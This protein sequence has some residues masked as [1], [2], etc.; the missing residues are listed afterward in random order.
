[1]SRRQVAV[2]AAFL[3]V[4]LGLGASTVG[5][6]TSAHTSEEAIGVSTS[7]LGT[8]NVLTRAYDNRRSGANTAESILTPSN[9]GSGNLG[10]L[11]QVQV[12]DEVY[13]QILYA[14][15][16]PLPG[17]SRNVIYVATANNS[18]YAIDA[19]TGVVIWQKNY[20]TAFVSTAT[21]PTWQQV[22]PQT[23]PPGCPAY[24]SHVGLIATPVIDAST[25]KMYFVTHTIENGSMVYR[26]HGIDIL[27]GAEASG[28][29]TIMTASGFDSTIQNQRAGLALD[30]GAVYVAFASYC[31]SNGDN[32]PTGYHGWVFAYD[33]SRFYQISA[34]NATPASGALGGIWQ[35]G[36]APAID[37]NG[38][39]YV[40]TGNG[41][42][43]GMANFGE[44]V[45]QLSSRTLRLQT[46]YTPSNFSGLNGQDLDLGAI[47][48]TL[49]S[50]GLAIQGGK[51][52][53]IYNL[54][55]QSLAANPNQ[56]PNPVQGSPVGEYDMH[57]FAVWNNGSADKIYMW[58]AN[59]LPRGFQANGGVIGTTPFAV[60]TIPTT[61]S[62]G[63]MSLSANGTSAG[64]LWAT[65]GLGDKA[66]NENFSVPGVLY[67]LDAATLVQ[68]WSSA[69][70]L[71]Q[72]NIGT[73]A[74][75]VPPTVANGKVYVASG[76]TDVV[77]TFGL[78][79]D[80]PV[81]GD[82]D[83]NGTATIGVFRTAGAPFNP[84]SSQDQWLLR[85][86]DSPG[87]PDITF[88]YGQ[89]GD[90]P[91]VGDWD[92]NGT[93][94]IGVFRPAG[95]QWLLRNS[96][97]PGNPD[98][99]FSYGQAG[100]IPV[101]G[102][103]TGIAST[104]IGVF[105]PA[106][107]LNSSD[108]WLL[109]NSNSG[110]NPDISF[111]YGARNDIP[112]TGDWDG[113]GTT[114]IGVFRSPGLFNSSTSDL[115]LLRNSNSPGSPDVS[116]SYGALSDI[117][118]VGRWTGIASTTIGV[119]RPGRGPANQT[120]SDQWLLR[121]SNTPGSADISFYYGAAHP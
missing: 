112:V 73:Y 33:S 113:N 7:A 6:S 51:E 99:S 18:I 107:D 105:R 27:S 28:S 70:N 15:A 1:V 48:P 21:A 103:W 74:K 38:N 109:R 44:S 30:N 84:S 4:A 88:Y 46:H 75:F 66:T 96:N 90:V 45:L 60:G 93:V 115:W 67:A 68:V 29:G 12:D 95:A 81:V 87:N 31:D 25:S 61:G 34:F 92:G 50:S 57:T 36:G 53:K 47:G 82:W 2:R 24:H 104:T 9:V 121:N 54:V 80:A 101:V 94:T 86:S 78:V 102:R 76:V 35:S 14:S 100:D 64:L 11:F 62:G 97:S 85:N 69:G 79:G 59:D 55:A 13:A 49:F 118:V 117:P 40:T 65:V 119:F 56:N 108:S 16:V 63:S 111:A 72:N 52:G 32:N 116:V 3:I 10:R 19:D 41:L 39:V 5:C 91:V 17:G 37:A 22:G 114:T 71:S 110:G 83:G 42:Y 20:T 89:A 26:I 98:I 58:A 77:S 43:D 120:S 106:P 23:N 8:L